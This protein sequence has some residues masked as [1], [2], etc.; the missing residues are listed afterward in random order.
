MLRHKK[1]NNNSDTA[2][3]IQRTMETFNYSPV[4]YQTSSEY[5]DVSADRENWA[6]KKIEGIAI[7]EL[8]DDVLDP[9]IDAACRLEITKA[10]AQHIKHVKTI[11]IIIEK[12]LS[13]IDRGKNILNLL[14]ADHE[15][16][17]NEREKL[18]KL[19]GN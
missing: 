3:I 13:Q 18:E 1:N 5:N 6:S 15:A 10:H 9:I 4:D 8:S 16:F 11:K 2:F 19:R 7:N 17:V 14:E 12:C